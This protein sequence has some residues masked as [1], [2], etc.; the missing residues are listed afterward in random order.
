MPQRR[1]KIIFMWCQI[2]C[3]S[4]D[5]IIRIKKSR[6]QEWWQTY[7][8]RSHYS[9]AEQVHRGIKIERLLGQKLQ[10]GDYRLDHLVGFDLHG[11]KNYWNRENRRR[12][13]KSCMVLV[14][15]FCL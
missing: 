6:A 1:G 3:R 7:P 10:M 13:A 4:V 14:A 11:K 2:Y 15:K 5:L 8:R 9:V 12:F